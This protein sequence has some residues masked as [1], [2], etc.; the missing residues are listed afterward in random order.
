MP[1]DRKPHPPLCTSWKCV[2]LTITVAVGLLVPVAGCV[3]PTVSHVAIPPSQGVVALPEIRVVQLND[4]SSVRFARVF[5]MRWTGDTL[6]IRGDVDRPGN[7]KTISFQRSRISELLVF[8]EAV[9]YKAFGGGLGALAG[10]GSM[11]FV[12]CTYVLRCFS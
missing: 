1:R 12:V 3:I 10:F 4:G 9:G 11:F 8:D 6:I 5:E 2:I 7:P